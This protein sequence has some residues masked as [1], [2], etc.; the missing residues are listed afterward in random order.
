MRV[1]ASALALSAVRGAVFGVDVS[2]PVSAE[3]AKCMFSANI[4]FGV[5]RAWHSDTEGFDKFAVTSVASWQ[6]ERIA[7]DVY[8]F[9]CSFENATAQVTQ[10][11][12][13][14]TASGTAPG[15]IWFDV[16]TNPTPACAWRAS[17]ADNCA[18]LGE[19][20]A[21]AKASPF[22]HWG[23]YTS[24]HMWTTLMTT[25]AA[26]DACA[27]A[28]DLPLWYPHYE[29]PPSPSFSDFVPFGGWAKPTIKQYYDGLTPGGLCG[30]SVD[31]NFAPAYP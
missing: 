16:E 20:V 19:L 17:K 5:A 26:P 25:A 31:N 24:I 7:A 18:Y 1:L 8:M 14:L 27:V 10:L 29:S 2:T 12:G 30:V 4:S 9:P 3:A 28:A 13:N 15:R 11:L 22:P 6:R 21:A 23:V